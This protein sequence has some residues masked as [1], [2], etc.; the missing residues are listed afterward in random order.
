[1][2][3]FPMDVPAEIHRWVDYGAADGCG[4]TDVTV[5]KGPLVM[6][7]HGLLAIDP[8]GR[9]GCWITSPMGDLTPRQAK[10]VLRRW[11]TRPGA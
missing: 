9:E 2:Q 5:A 11:S 6:M 7:A 4:R 1:M 8:L 10:A 3:L